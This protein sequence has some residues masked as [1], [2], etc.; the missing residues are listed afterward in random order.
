MYMKHSRKLFSSIKETRQQSRDLSPADSTR[1]YGF[2]EG[3][4]RH[5]VPWWRTG[6][7]LLR[8]IGGGVSGFDN[9]LDR[10]RWPSKRNIF[11]VDGDFYPRSASTVI[12]AVGDARFH[13]SARNDRLV[14][15][16]SLPVCPSYPFPPLLALLGWTIP[17]LILLSSILHSCWALIPG[18]R[19]RAFSVTFSL[20]NFPRS[21]PF[22]FSPAVCVAF[23]CSSFLSLIRSRRSESTSY[24]LD[25]FSPF[26]AKIISRFISG[27]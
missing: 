19:P 17:I 1:E 8:A 12:D 26:R 15:W 23:S 11:A 4:R 7:S 21:L 16:H 6:R 3:V 10:N 14:F 13:P 5:H 2:R 22:S 20:V 27:E 24:T 9:S 25:P 18:E